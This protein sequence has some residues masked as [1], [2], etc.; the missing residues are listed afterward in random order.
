MKVRNKWGYVS[1]VTGFLLVFFAIATFLLELQ[2]NNSNYLNY[3]AFYEFAVPIISF[4]LI[5]GAFFVVIGTVYL[6]NIR[7]KWSYASI[8]VG[9]TLINIEAYKLAVALIGTREFG[10]GWSDFQT[11]WALSFFSFLMAGVFFIISGIIA[12]SKVRSKVGYIIIIGGATIMLLGLSIL[13]IN[14]ATS[15]NYYPPDYYF[16]LRAAW[17][18]TITYL[19]IIGAL[20]VAFGTGYLITVRKRNQNSKE[21]ISVK[22]V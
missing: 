12:G 16:S 15:L 10:I 1:S 9:F 11:Y 18:T 2:I 8:T 21:L 22:K 3:T 6:R 13:A 5:A 20:I 4:C 7:N 17:N 19:L 14:L